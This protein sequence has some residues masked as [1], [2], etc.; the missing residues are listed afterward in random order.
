MKNWLKLFFTWSYILET[1]S[2]SKG[3][4]FLASRY[5]SIISIY[6]TTNAVFDISMAGHKC[7]LSMVIGLPEDM[8]HHSLLALEVQDYS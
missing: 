7:I 4:F 2:I 3:R 8:N 1:S 6:D 5:L